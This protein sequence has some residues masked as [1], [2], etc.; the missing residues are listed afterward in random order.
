M[1]ALAGVVLV[2]VKSDPGVDPSSA[3]PVSEVT[4][5]PTLDDPTPPEAEEHDH[6]VDPRQARVAEA[7]GHA[8]AATTGRAQWLRELRPLVTSELLAGFE[9]TARSSRPSG[10]VV[11]VIHLSPTD[12]FEIVYTSGLRLRVV[13]AMAGSAWLVQDV[14]PISEPLPSGTDV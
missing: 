1:V 13:L 8:F 7:F 9:Y 5:S 2:G 6:P 11:H 10:E 14:I 4:S 12:D 3:P